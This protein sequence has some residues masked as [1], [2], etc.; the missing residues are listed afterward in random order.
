M[1]N[2]NYA[3][4]DIPISSFSEN[5]PMPVK[6][7]YLLRFAVLAPSG[8]NSQP[9]RCQLSGNVLN[10]NY[11]PERALAESDSE[12][13]MLFVA[14]GCFLEN[15]LIAANYFGVKAELSHNENSPEDNLISITFTPAT[16]DHKE[17][18]LMLSI[19]KRVSNR[20]KYRNQTI[21]EPVIQSLSNLS[22]N[23]CQIQIVIEKNKRESLAKIMENAQIEAM[24]SQT[25]RNELSNYLKSNFTKDSFGMPGFTLDMPTPFSIIAS[26]LVKKINLSRLTAKKDLGLLL[27]HTPALGIISIDENNKSAW[28]EAGRT[29]ERM[30][31]S[32][33]Q[34]GLACSVWAAAAQ[35]KDYT[36]QVRKLLNITSYP[37]VLFRI[38][39]PKKNPRHSPRFSVEQIL[40]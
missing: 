31:L 34:Q 17:E 23:A 27:K 32:A 6:I 1:Q 25:F 24:K 20:Y 33:T 8:H 22:S 3:A 35:L 19:V 36:E 16:A 26:K 12:G 37:I 18:P 15:L 40:I 30:W 21:P 7:K 28:L 2:S 13:R 9:W 11:S 39:Y 10:L 29:F 4:W 38:G 5:D 14:L